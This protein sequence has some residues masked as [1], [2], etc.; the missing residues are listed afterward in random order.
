MIGILTF[1][2]VPN[3]GAFCQAYALNKVISSITDE[4]V[5]HIGY[6]NS[7]HRGLYEKRKKPKINSA[8]SI[9]SPAFHKAYLMYYLFPRVEYP[10]FKKDWDLIPHID[11]ND[12]E[13]MEKFRFNNI[14]LG[15]DSIWE[16]STKDFGCD[17]HFVGLNLN[18]ERIG[19]YAPSFGD[20][21]PE[22]NFDEFVSRG[23]ANIESLTVRDSSSANIVEKLTGK[24]P[25]I[26]LDPTFLWDF[27]NDENI[28]A[29]G[30]GKYILVYGDNFE[31][32]VIKDVKEYANKCGLKIIGVGIAPK[33]CDVKMT[34]ISPFEWIS[35][36]K[37]AEL[38]VTC[39]FHGLMF[40]IHFKRKV[41]F[42]QIDHVKN[43]SQWLLEI[44]GL[45][46]LYHD[47]SLMRILE[48]E[49]DYDS[50]NNKIAP[51]IKESMEQLQL[52]VCR[53]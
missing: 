28:K 31:P 23:I 3:Y 19:A 45:E 51:K 32:K 8:R 27:N 25:P 10:H 2:G 50:I 22:D 17:K 38:V 33:W 35:M 14:I 49:W 6:L 24:V 18:T 12:E 41:L 34:N 26:V 48:F 21:N 46:D 16:Y 11:F 9:L 37:G 53:D 42:Q 47:L 30:K 39:T 44:T 36:F 52:M 13:S 15:S 29:A 1:W 7:T 20:M 40:S 5:R 4:E 43:R